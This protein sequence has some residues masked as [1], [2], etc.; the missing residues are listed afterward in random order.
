[1]IMKKKMQQMPITREQAIE[2]LK[3]MPQKDSDWNH[4]LESEA[5]MRAVAEK[6]GEDVEY[7]GMLGLLHDVDWALT[8]ENWEEHCVKAEEILKENYFDEEFIQTIQS[9]GYGYNE[10]PK[11]K[12]K[13]REK[14]IE[15]ALA[16]SETVTGLIY[17]YAL[18][19]G[20]KISDMDISGL[21]KKFKD[22]SFA[23]N[24]NREIIKEIEQIMP[25][26]EFFGIAIKAMQG[27]KEDIGLE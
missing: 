15:H 9:H 25:L 14:K 18:M 5:I 20:R 7:W 21:K 27:I 3:N 6:F 19:R 12:D 22:K 16:A 1:M 23:A 10:I 11:F 8:K 17:A 24:C 4:Y 26:D 13:K 2:L